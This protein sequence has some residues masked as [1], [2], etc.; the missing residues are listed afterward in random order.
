[1]ERSEFIERLS[2]RALLQKDKAT[3]WST[4]ADTYPY[5][6][7][8]Q[9]LAYQKIGE[10]TTTSKSKLLLHF[11]NPLHL[12]ATLS[13]KGEKK[14]LVLEKELVNESK[15]VSKKKKLRVAPVAKPKEE[16]KVGTPLAKEE[17]IKKGA[18]QNLETTTKPAEKTVDIAT[19]KSVTEKLPI[20]SKPN[21]KED[22]LEL[23]NE[24]PDESP[25]KKK[26]TSKKEEKVEVEEA[27]PQDP[28]NL[29]VMMSFTDW[30]NHFKTKS[31]HEA[32]EKKGKD[33][34]RSAWQ[35]E[36]LAEAMD[37]E[38]DVVPDDIFE[39]AMKSV[40]FGDGLVTE[41]LAELYVQQGKTDKAIELYKKLS[42]LNPEKRTYF[43]SRIKDLHLL[44]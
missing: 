6:S 16:E 44:K 18:V 36:K 4:L 12:A 31:E 26:D 22:V 29:M 21:E 13:N 34:I 27:S 8:I 35:K 14:S 32:E 17:I 39:K 3:N 9:L 15:T 28:G 40:S 2:K 38:E 5:A 20:E 7:L 1:M 37:D 19:K 43:A 42:L 41:P 30:L 23:I 24:L 11:D 25:I 33:A 10:T